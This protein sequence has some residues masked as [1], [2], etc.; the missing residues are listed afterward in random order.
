LAEAAGVLR[1]GGALSIAGVAA[2]RVGESSTGLGLAAAPANRVGTPRAYFRYLQ[3][4]GALVEDAPGWWRVLFRER[5]WYATG[6]LLSLLLAA[7]LSCRRG[8]AV[9]GVFWAA[10]SATVSL[11]VGIYLYQ[12]L[13]GQAFWAVSLLSAASMVGIL[14][15]TR[16][17][18]SGLAQWT[19]PLLAAVPAVLF[20]LYPALQWVPEA[21][22]LGALLGLVAAAGAGLGQVFARCCGQGRSPTDGGRLFA[23][24]LL[25]AGAGLFLGGVLLPWWSGFAPTAALGAAA[26]VVGVA[27]DTLRVRQ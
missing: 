8:R 14:A 24:D 17:R 13:A 16:M 4:R 20:P 19:A 12:S 5:T 1:G 25:G 23:V 21:A 18:C 10:W 9:Q 27:L 6:L 3:F 22:V 26:A 15:G 2:G 11:I 7:G